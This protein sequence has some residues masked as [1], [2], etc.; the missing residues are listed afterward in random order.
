MFV[1]THI[2]KVG[3]NGILIYFQ[4]YLM[5]YLQN[6]FFLTCPDNSKN[7]TEKN[8]HTYF[9]IQTFSVRIC[10]KHLKFSCFMSFKNN[11][12]E[13]NHPLMCIVKC[14]FK[15]PFNKIVWDK[16]I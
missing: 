8:L 16:Y 13:K 7:K 15:F 4:K 14:F 10:Y 1:I 9:Y 12:Y 6:C 3:V 2:Q 5:R 11:D